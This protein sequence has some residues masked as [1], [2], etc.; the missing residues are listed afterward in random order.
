MQGIWAEHERA[1]ER[2]TDVLDPSERRDLIR[3]LLK[4]KRGATSPQEG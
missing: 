3:L 1:L 2:A 4:L